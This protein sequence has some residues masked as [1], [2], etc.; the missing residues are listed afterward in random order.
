MPIHQVS[1]AETEDRNLSPEEFR[2]LKVSKTKAKLWRRRLIC[3]ALVII[4]AVLAAVPVYQLV[5]QPFQAKSVYNQMKRLY[6]SSGSG[7]MP[8]E[9]NED[10]EALYDVNPDVGGWMIVGE[11]PI[12]LPV[13]QTLAHDSV[14]YVNH[15]FDGT[16]NPY[17]TPY[18]LT[19]CTLGLPAHNTVIRGGE[20]LMGELGSYR[21]LDYYK[22]EPKMFLSGLNETESYKIFAIVEVAEGEVSEFSKGVYET[23]EEFRDF[24]ERMGE[25]TLINTGITVTQNDSL[26]TLLCDT[27]AGKLAIIG[28]AVRDGESFEVDTSQATLNNGMGGLATWVDTPTD[29]VTATDTLGATVTKTDVAATNSAIKQ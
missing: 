2:E 18:F 22:N 20:K 10:F 7:A 28:R 17:G 15:L 16:S 26:L 3:F 4:L 25:R 14:Y 23:T 1:S 13:V 19:D 9:F 6:A 8:E 21:T 12:E 11:S 5:Y 24:V 29:V 27:E